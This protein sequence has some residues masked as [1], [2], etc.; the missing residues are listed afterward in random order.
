MS[1]NCK[2]EVHYVDGEGVVRINHVF[3]FPFPKRRVDESV[4]DFKARV[5]TAV[6][7]SSDVSAGREITIVKWVGLLGYHQGYIDIPVA[8]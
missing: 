6:L 5:T 2:G 8:H 1:E 4:I 3:N 7:R